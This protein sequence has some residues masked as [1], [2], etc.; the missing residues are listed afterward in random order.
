MTDQSDLRSVAPQAEEVDDPL[1]HQ[2]ASKS[3]RQHRIFQD[4]HCLS[5]SCKMSRAVAISTSD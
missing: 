3:A 5:D 4:V 2:Q 1:T